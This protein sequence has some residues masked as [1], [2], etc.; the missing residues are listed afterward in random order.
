MDIATSFVKKVRQEAM[1]LDPKMYKI[2]KSLYSS[3]FL[4]YRIEI[5]DMVQC[6]C[7][8][9]LLLLISGVTSGYTN[10]IGPQ[11]N[12]HFKISKY[13]YS[14]IYIDIIAQECFLTLMFPPTPAAQTA[15]AKWQRSLLGK[16]LFFLC[17]GKVFS[18]I[19]SHFQ[20]MW[21]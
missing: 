4:S 1:S 10:L 12:D 16:E 6:H 9:F 13:S 17:I 14:Y 19:T 20:A 2:S 8:I 15:A 7:N 5:I 11:N 21:L 3:L 18:I